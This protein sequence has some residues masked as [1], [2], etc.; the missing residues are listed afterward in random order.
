MTL[1]QAGLRQVAV[2]GSSFQCEGS[3][4]RV[5]SPFQVGRSRSESNFKDFFVFPEIDLVLSGA[6]SDQSIDVTSN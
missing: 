6:I 1:S 4:L 5:A 2:Y 3:E